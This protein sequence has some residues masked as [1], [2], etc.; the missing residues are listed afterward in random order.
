MLSILTVRGHVSFGAG[1]A[2]RGGVAAGGGPPHTHP[3]YAPGRRRN[4]DPGNR[5]ATNLAAIDPNGTL[6]G[7]DAFLGQI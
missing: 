6:A 4:A 2:G 1:L 3:G 5:P 7:H